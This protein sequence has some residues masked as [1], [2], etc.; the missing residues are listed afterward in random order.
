MNEQRIVRTAIVNWLTHPPQGHARVSV[1]SHAFSA[2]PF[3]F[4]GEEAENEVTTPGELLG[5]THGSALAMFLARIL[6]REGIAARELVVHVAYTFVGDW[7]EIEAVSFAVRG[8]VDGAERDTFERAVR[9]ALRCCGESL[10]L[11]SDD[12][13]ELRTE[14]L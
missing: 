8:R 5:A 11:P 12:R 10:G 3:S 4:A 9:H 2:L 14:L 6:E 7:Y 13:V 1:G